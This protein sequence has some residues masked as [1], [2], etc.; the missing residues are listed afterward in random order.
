MASQTAAQT[1][2]PSV[3]HGQIF[4]N[5][6]MK[7]QSEQNAEMHSVSRGQRSTKS[8]PVSYTEREPDSQVST[9]QY[10]GKK[11]Q[12]RFS[13]QLSPDT[14]RF[15]HYVGMFDGHGTSVFAAD[16][17][18]TELT[19]KLVCRDEDERKKLPSN[20]QIITA[21]R[22][23]HDVVV[24]NVRQHPRTGTTAVTLFIGKN[25]LGGPDQAKVAWCGDSRAVMV[26]LSTGKTVSL[27]KDHS[28]SGNPDEVTRI[29]N[30]EHSPRDGLI[31]SP[32]WA[33]E[34]QMCRERGTR[35]RSGSFVGRRELNGREAGPLVV[36]AYTGGVSLQVSRSIGD[37]LAARSCIPDPEI[38]VFDLPK[39][40]RVRFI[41]ASDG[42]WDVY[43]SEAAGKMVYHVQ[44][45]TVAARKLALAA[46]AKRTQMGRTIDDIT[47]V[48][49]DY[50]NLSGET[51]QASASAPKPASK[52]DRRQSSKSDC[53][54][55]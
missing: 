18:A 28:L 13:V 41:V 43:T 34:E 1:Y 32:L 15:P 47:V 10:P 7:A 4:T 38:A 3:D 40:D 49:L 51:T 53:V 8:E 22:Q 42:L 20:Q 14:S 2:E 21:Y 48:V 23:V 5:S 45:C 30:A 39:N 55:Q 11:D 26:S 52:P 50:N 44:D 31:E 46:R 25:E 33:I 27:T 17:C 16:L 54:V 12:D 6:D 9:C 37:T 19:S 35:A 24:R 29:T 36:F